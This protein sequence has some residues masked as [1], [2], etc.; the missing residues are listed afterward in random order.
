MPPLIGLDGNLGVSAK[1]KTD[2]L[3]DRFFTP[4]IA[5]LSD[6]T[7][8]FP[9]THTP[10]LDTSLSTISSS[11]PLSS[12]LFPISSSS[13]SSP[14]SS[15]LFPISSSSLSSPLSIPPPISSSSTCTSTSTSTS[16][17]TYTS[18]LPTTT[19]SPTTPSFYPVLPFDYSVSFEEVRQALKERKS[20]S[21][22]GL[23]TYPY[24]FLKALGSPFI[25]ILVSIISTL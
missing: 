18:A 6:I 15:S 25:N 16:T 7:H 14:S 19:L 8:A 22:P 9:P 21:C 10:S 5:D 2:I 13:L 20:F 12:S 4:S 3:F 11:S 24:A 1:E 17:S 23:D